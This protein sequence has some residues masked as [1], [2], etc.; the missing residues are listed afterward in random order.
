MLSVCL[1]YCSDGL[2][3]NDVGKYCSYTVLPIRET[4][5]TGRPLRWHLIGPGNHCINYAGNKARWGI[6]RHRDS[7]RKAGEV[8]LEISAA[9]INEW[10]AFFPRRPIRIARITSVHIESDGGMPG[11]SC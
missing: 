10:M 9:I 4:G 1:C 11:F 8:L 2:C 7:S 5:R 6:A 3:E